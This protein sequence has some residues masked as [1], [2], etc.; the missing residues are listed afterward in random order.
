MLTK[1]ELF[2]LLYLIFYKIYSLKL[3]HEIQSATKLYWREVCKCQ[4]R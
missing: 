3:H 4:Y 1:N 2:L